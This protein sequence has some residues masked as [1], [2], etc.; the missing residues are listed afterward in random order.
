[1]TYQKAVRF[2]VTAEG[3]LRFPLL[4]FAFYISAFTVT[5]T[6]FIFPFIDDLILV[7]AVLLLAVSVP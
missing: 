5:F 7:P 6:I 1:V 4:I 2:T 3:F